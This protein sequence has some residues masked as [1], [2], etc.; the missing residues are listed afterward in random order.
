MAYASSQPV[1]EVP[2]FARVGQAVRRGV[3]AA[4]NPIFGTPENPTKLGKAV[5]LAE[6]AS[7]HGLMAGPATG[8]MRYAVRAPLTV[9]P[10]FLGTG[11]IPLPNV[12]RSVSKAFV[13]R[14]GFS[15][16]P[17]DIQAVRD[18]L[19]EGKKVLVPKSMFSNAPG[20]FAYLDDVG[21]VVIPDSTAS[22]IKRYNDRYVRV[23]PPGSKTPRAVSMTEVEKMAKNVDKANAPYD[24]KQANL[25]ALSDAV[26]PYWQY[27]MYE[28]DIASLNKTLADYRAPKDRVTKRPV[29]YKNKENLSFDVLS[30]ESAQ[31]VLSNLPG[32]GYRLSTPGFGAVDYMPNHVSAMSRDRF[33]KP[34][35]TLFDL[36]NDGYLPYQSATF[37]GAERKVGGRTVRPIMRVTD[38]HEFLDAPDG[39]R[40]SRV[41]N[42]DFP[43][44]Y[45]VGREVPSYKFT[46]VDPGD[47]EAVYRLDGKPIVPSTG[48]YTASIGLQQASK[49]GD[50]P[51]RNFRNFLASDKV[52]ESIF[53]YR[54][55]QRPE[56][57]APGDVKFF[58]ANPKAAGFYDL[59]EGG[60]EMEADVPRQAIG[61]KG[62]PKDVRGLVRKFKDH[63]KTY[64]NRE[65][66]PYK[67]VDGNW[68]VGYGS[69]FLADGTPVTEKTA[70]TG[71]MIDDAFDTDLVRRIDLLAGHDRRQAR[72]AVPNWRYMS[73]ESRLMLLDVS[74][75]RKTTLTSGNS[76]GLFGELRAAGKDTAALDEIV[77]RHYPSYRY[78]KDENGTV[79]KSKTEGLQNRRIALLKALTGEDFSYKGKKWDKAEN[80]FTEE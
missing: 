3:L 69:H 35:S 76:P 70:V 40:L 64:E 28:R 48:R 20:D 59:G 46:P 10:R 4:L 25:R 43:R 14:S 24:L 61:A 42:K 62:T 8:M 50:S 77:K 22:L 60:E 34:G 16:M 29:F 49:G 45:H 53:G 58:R 71:A 80:R 54:V 67:D 7:Q 5:A 6:E 37:L 36:Y 11:T 32:T 23:T 74:W 44:V 18:G 17:R 21:N 66:K 52:P 47:I 9:D 30:A 75:G 1:K 55:V 41:A 78:A 15:S 56:D 72:Y 2:G 26:N 68:A 51:H 57:Y 65:V 38:H 12:Q 31:T 27:W 13:P 39:F 63:I 73:P 33:V 79:D 19:A